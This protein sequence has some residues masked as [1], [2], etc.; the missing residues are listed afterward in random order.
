MSHTVFNTKKWYLYTLLAFC[1]FWLTSIA[2]ADECTDFNYDYMDHQVGGNECNESMVLNNKCFCNNI[3]N[4]TTNGSACGS[5]SPSGVEQ[6]CSKVCGSSDGQTFF[7]APSINLCNYGTPTQVNGVGPWTW[8][9]VGDTYAADW[10]KSPYVASCSSSLWVSVPT[11]PIVTTPV[12][13]TP[14]ASVAG[15]PT[16]RPVQCKDSWGNV[17]DDSFCNA[18]T[19]PATEEN[20]VCAVQAAWWNVSWWVCT[21]PQSCQAIEDNLTN[22]DT[23]AQPNAC[24]NPA[25]ILTCLVMA[26]GSGTQSGTVACKDSAGNVLPDSQC[27]ATTKPSTTQSCT[28]TYG[29][30]EGGFSTCSGGSASACSYVSPG[31][32]YEKIWIDNV[33]PFERT[34]NRLYNSNRVEVGS[35]PLSV[36]DT[37]SNLGWCPLC[38]VNEEVYVPFCTHPVFNAYSDYDDYIAAG[39]TDLSESEF[40]GYVANDEQ[41]YI[42]NR[43]LNS[44][45]Y[46][47]F[48][49]EW[50]KS[51]RTG[52]KFIKPDNAWTCTTTW[53]SDMDSSTDA[54]VAPKT[55]RFTNDYVCSS[56]DRACLEN[57]YT[58]AVPSCNWTTQNTCTAQS[59]SC[60]WTE[61]T[62]PTQSQTVVCKDA[63]GNQV[64]DSNCTAVK[65]ATY[66]TCSSP[67]D[68]ICG[69]SAWVC[70]VWTT[71]L[72]LPG[73]P[74]T[75]S[76]FGSNGGT[77]A[78]CSV[79]SSYKDGVLYNGPT[80]FDGH[81][82]MGWGV[83]TGE[84][85]VSESTLFRLEVTADNTNTNGGH[86]T[87]TD[88]VLNINGFKITEAVT[89][90]DAQVTKISTL[91]LPITTLN[92]FLPYTLE[93]E[94]IFTEAGFNGYGR[95]CI[96]STPE[97]PPVN[98][99]CDSSVNNGCTVWTLSDTTD[100]STDYLWSCMGSNGGATDSCT[101]AKNTL[102]NGVCGSSN[103]ATLTSEPTSIPGL[104]SAG[105]YTNVV[106][107]QGEYD[108]WKWTCQWENG[109]TTASCSAEKQY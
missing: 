59:S 106:F 61:G 102:V 58:P 101:R 87:F 79:P 46:K 74:T 97:F 67:V 53:C 13:T 51:K 19:K 48:W 52:S 43:L 37:L 56:T 60:R 25:N 28:T 70:A 88:G 72:Y 12:I 10:R 35:M 83:I 64:S 3:R 71:A 50:Y 7:S 5:E 91:L 90:D 92:T 33:T 30:S 44:Q 76:C 18:T 62:S 27:D 66:K 31:P 22:I 38:S 107:S 40:Y 49:C 45:Y 63:S 68:G 89:A 80:C 96:V 86:Y 94:E 39:Y 32:S 26:S 77:T 29:W 47:R 69:V 105:N 100:S 20:Q 82:P 15:C 41:L 95:V 78:S 65:P 24:T 108:L 34:E 55:V 85:L 84:L 99:A 2:R 109:G 75:W 21:Y 98:G 9:C 73:A 103:G 57:R 4:S 11:T 81:S 1:I 16:C 104:C 14:T 54:L 42:Y 36:N 8:S 17:V 93:I 6:V 23:C